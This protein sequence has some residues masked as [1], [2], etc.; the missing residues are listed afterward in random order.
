MSNFHN[1]PFS[2]ISIINCLSVTQLC[3][4]SVI[5]TGASAVFPISSESVPFSPYSRDMP[6]LCAPSDP[7]AYQLGVRRVRRVTSFWVKPLYTRAYI[8]T[9]SCFYP[10][11]PTPTT[12]MTQLATML[13]GVVGVGSG[14]SFS[15]ILLYYTRATALPFNKF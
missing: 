8:V 11:L 14:A 4:L 2:E 1:W 5:F 10:P 7:S 6:F 13:L 15:V 9:L 3:I 12:P